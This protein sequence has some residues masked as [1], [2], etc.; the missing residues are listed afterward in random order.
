MFIC[1]NFLKNGGKIRVYVQV[2]VVQ[3]RLGLGLSLIV[4]T[5]VSTSD[6]RTQNQ[7]FRNIHLYR[8]QALLL[9]FD[10]ATI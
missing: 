5:A 4:W 3:V 6:M 9:L 7:K 10:T 2:S 8:R 1:R